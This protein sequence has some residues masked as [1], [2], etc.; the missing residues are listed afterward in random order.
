MKSLEGARENI[1]EIY[2]QQSL[3]AA[4]EGAALILWPESTIPTYFGY[5]LDLQLQHAMNRI[6][7]NCGTDIL[8]G[9]VDVTQEGGGTRAYNSA[10]LIHP[11]G[12]PPQKYDKR[13]LVPWG[14]YVP[15]KRLFSFLDRIVQGISDFSAG[16]ENQPLLRTE[17]ALPDRQEGLP[18][19][20]GI[21]Y[22]IIFPDLIRGMVDRGAEFIT[23]LTNDAWFGRTSAPHQHF[24]MAVFRAVENRRYV[25]R[26]AT[27]GI[28]G[29][30]D[31]FGRIVLESSLYE[32]EV[33]MAR[34]W[35]VR[36]KT[37][38]T[39]YGDF[40]S[41]LMIFLSFSLLIL[42]YLKAKYPPRS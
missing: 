33:L 35:P 28:S 42:I 30:I 14:E 11:S 26:C 17:T 39:R 22:E 9:S 40:F 38:Y 23:T 32:R 34:I 10:F 20:V 13:H 41:H 7:K 25:V 4:A 18:F 12:R 6:L 2:R 37:F 3:E 1:E 5:N 27:T 8:F 16:G 21:C 31:P 15:L 36:K 24:G 19:C 29:I